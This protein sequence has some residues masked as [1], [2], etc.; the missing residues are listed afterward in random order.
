MKRKNYNR[1]KVCPYPGCG[2]PILNWAKT[3]GKHC[4]FDQRTH[5]TYVCPT[6]GTSFERQPSQVTT[7]YPKCS[8]KCG[9]THRIGKA[10]PAAR[11]GI[12]VSDAQM[13]ADYAQSKNCL[14]IALKYHLSPSGVAHRLHCLGVELWTSSPDGHR[15]H[16]GL[17]FTVDVWL[18]EH[19]LA[20]EI[21]PRLPWETRKRADFLVGDTYI[22]V[23]GLMAFQDYSDSVSIKLAEYSDHHVK[24]LALTRKQIY[25]GDFSP[26]ASLLAGE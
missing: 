20:H 23:F 9:Y 11:R 10:V 12:A 3:C 24:V 1:G 16:S 19:S 7:E 13:L 25:A 14:P 5:Q 17:E 6:C 26:L 22:E 2:K 21:H 8:R 4:H 18:N 15:A